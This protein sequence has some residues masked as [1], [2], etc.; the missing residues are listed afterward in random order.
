MYLMAEAA[1]RSSVSFKNRK[2]KSRQAPAYYRE[3]E[4]L[5]HVNQNYGH[6]DK[7]AGKECAKGHSDTHAA[8]ICDQVAKKSQTGNAKD[9]Y[10]SVIL[11]DQYRW[12]CKYQIGVNDQADTPPH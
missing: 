2:H 6:I 9:K 7:Q 4:M 8:H 10:G 11:P 5:E 12:D 3:K 1:Q